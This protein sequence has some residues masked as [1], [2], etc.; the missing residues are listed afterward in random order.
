MQNSYFDDDVYTGFW[1]NRSY[2]PIYGATLTL[3]RQGGGFLIAFL[4]VYVGMAGKSFWKITRFLLH[5]FF[6]STT[7]PNGIYH[8]RQAILRNSKSALD[9]VEEI[10]H[11]IFAW[12]K[13]SRKNPLRLVPVLF[14]AF[15]I[16]ASFAI[17]GNS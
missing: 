16:T 2:G 5:S 8:Q 13:Q 14:L 10:L 12:R 7:L 3:S 6:S 17:A 9:A 11:A 4:A 1:I 15:V